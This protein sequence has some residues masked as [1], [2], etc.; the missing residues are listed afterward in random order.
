MSERDGIAAYEDVR[1]RLTDLVRGLDDATLASKLPA[2]PDWTVK[3]VVCHVTGITTDVLGGNL[4]GVGGDEWTQAQVDARCDRPIADILAEWEQNAPALAEGMR[5]AGPA[6]AGVLVGD[7]ATHDF[8]ARGGLGNTEGRD[9]EATYVAFERYA[10][11]LGDRVKG[12]GLPALK[13]DAGT[14]TVVAGEGEPAQP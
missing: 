4:E 12:A 3:D 9:S 14:S 13:L 2:C 5:A 8:D 11:G 6:M 7:L 1:T 10:N